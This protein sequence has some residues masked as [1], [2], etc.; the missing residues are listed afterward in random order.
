MFFVSN[1]QKIEIH[2]LDGCAMQSTWVYIDSQ[3]HE[4]IEN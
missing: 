2:I 4:K 3:P 1:I